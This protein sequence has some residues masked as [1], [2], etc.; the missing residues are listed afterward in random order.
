[1]WCAKCYTS[2]REV[3]FFV[4]EPEDDEGI[5]WKRARDDNRL[6]VG[7]NGDHVSTPFQCDLCVFRLL[8]KSEPDHTSAQDSLLLACIRRVNLD[9]FWSREKSTVEGN[10]NAM[11]RAIRL[12]ESMGL[13]GGYPAPGPFPLFDNCGYEVAIQMVLASKRPGRNAGSYTQFDTIRT[14]RSSFFNAWQVSQ[15]TRGTLLASTDERGMFSR[16]GSCPTQSLWFSR[17]LQGCRGRMGQLVLQD[18]AISVDL[19]LAVLQIVDG[20]VRD[21]DDLTEKTWWVTVGAFLTMGFCCSL[22]GP[23]GFMLDL[24]GLRKFL[25]QGRDDAS[26]PFVVIPLLGRFKGEEHFRQHLLVSASETAS[27]L[28]P[29]KWLE[30]LIGLHHQQGRVRGP[31]ICD[32]DGFVVKQS[33]MNAAFLS[34]LETVREDSPDL[35]PP[36]QSVPDYDVDRSLRRG[37][38]S[39]AK[40]LGIS[41]QDI[42]AMNR[43]RIFERARG[44][45]PAQSMSDGYADVELLRPMFL[46]YTQPL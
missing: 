45:K 41:Q 30:A 26:D 28:R 9:A 16:M 27:G 20:R 4:K 8:R 31:A 23:E 25:G 21:S 33:V 43:W 37:S 1:M 24:H 38:D 34:C 14:Y 18:K 46:R 44:R 40:A 3:T 12:S 22:R 32:K 15:A 35:F 11:K 17:F 2:D 19:L 36:G 42:D 13:D 5:P 29:R 7:R 39:R 10:F 6:H